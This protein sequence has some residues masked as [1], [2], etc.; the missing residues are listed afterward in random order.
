MI[1]IPAR[2]HPFPLDIAR[3]ALLVIDVQNDFCHPEGYCLGDM[4]A[5]TVTAARV[6]SIIPRLQ[7]LIAWARR[8]RMPVIFTKEAH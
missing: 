5:D 3:C 1:S 4:G 8:N 7:R 6:R 2:P